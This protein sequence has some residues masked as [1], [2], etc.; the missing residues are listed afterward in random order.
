MPRDEKHARKW[1]ERQESLWAE[2]PDLPAR[3]EKLELSPELGA[4]FQE[5]DTAE[6][7]ELE[8]I[9]ADNVKELS[10][11][12]LPAVPEHSFTLSRSNPLICLIA[13]PWRVAERQ[14]SGR[15]KMRLGP[16]WPPQLIVTGLGSFSG[17][18]KKRLGV[19]DMTAL[20]F[21]GTLE[22]IGITC[23]GQMTLPDA[24]TR[25]LFRLKDMKAVATVAIERGTPQPFAPCP[26]R[27]IA[28]QIWTAPEAGDYD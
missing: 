6:S 24:A 14:D 16:V 19:I 7:Q 11:Q 2:F 22:D 12:G 18:R 21:R 13:R 28:R 5:R 8:S 9:I 25:V 4:W 10:R 23:D 15:K 1:R 20:G 3:G 17:K 26:E 27:W